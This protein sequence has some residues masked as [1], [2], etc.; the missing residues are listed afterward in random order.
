MTTGLH[1]Q[2]QT[3]RHPGFTLAELLVVIGIILL[4][5]A[6]LIPTVSSVRRAGMAA[7]TKALLTAIDGAIQAYYSDHQKWPGPLAPSQIAADAAA[8]DITVRASAEYVGNGDNLAMVTGT[9]NLVLGLLGGLV[10]VGGTVTYDPA[11]VGKGPANLGSKPGASQ[12]YLEVGTDDLSMHTANAEFDEPYTGVT[13]VAGKQWGRFVD[14]A[15]AAQD[16]I[17]PEFVDR[18][19]NPLP[20]LYLRSR[21]TNAASAIATDDGSRASYDLRGLQGYVGDTGGGT[22]IGVGRDALSDAHQSAATYHGL[23]TTGGDKTQDDLPWTG[24]AFLAAPNGTEAVQKDRYV[25]IS[26][27]A[28]RV[29]GTEDDIT[30]FGS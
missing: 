1:M 10:N 21:P 12:P 20:I 9:E 15:A 25:L 11:L 30:N 24:E 8:T 4:L 3:R 22:Y 26:A 14:E 13:G 6:I 23:L 29:Y 5:I 7:D 2:R 16:S 18:F 27:G 17:V 28:D 19:T